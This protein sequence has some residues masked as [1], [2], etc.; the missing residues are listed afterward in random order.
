MTAS[1][2]AH[3]QKKTEKIDVNKIRQFR[4]EFPVCRW[5][6]GGRWSQHFL[7]NSIWLKCI[8]FN[9]KLLYITLAIIT[10]LL[11]YF[12]TEFERDMER[13]KIPPKEF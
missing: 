2:L 6:A 13:P 7:I 5:G 1:V 3:L 11:K 8:V 9:L 12:L 10:H 4:C